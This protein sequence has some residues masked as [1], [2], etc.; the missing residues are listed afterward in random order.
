MKELNSLIGKTVTNLFVGVGENDLYFVTKE[1]I[2]R[3]P[4]YGDCC[5][6]TWFSD[7]TGFNALIG[8]PVISIE[9]KDLPQEEDG[10]T[11]Q[12]CD[13]FMGFTIKT[14]KG[15]SD[16]LYRNSSNG[17]YGGSAD[18]LREVVQ[19]PESAKEIMDDWSA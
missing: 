12:E 6:E 13:Q 11:R 9:E 17:C 14:E 18:D 19:V 4:T 15:H 3:L 10:R 8:S 1:Y 7:V 5:S 16:V 2:Y